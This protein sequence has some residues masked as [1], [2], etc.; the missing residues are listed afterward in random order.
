FKIEFNPMQ[1]RTTGK[2]DILRAGNKYPLM[3]SRVTLS[4]IC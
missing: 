4:N 2:K 3:V 1:D